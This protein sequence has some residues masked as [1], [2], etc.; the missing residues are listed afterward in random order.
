M[1]TP[2]ECIDAGVWV[3][4]QQ[5]FAVIANK[6]SAT[7]ALC[8]KQV[9]ETRLYEKLALTW[10]EFCKEYAGISRSQ[11]DRL[12]QQYEEF[13]DAYFRLSGIARVSPETYRLIA[14]QVS[15][16]GHEIDGQKLALI[17]ENGPRILARAFRRRFTGSMSPNLTPI[18]L[19][20]LGFFPREVTHVAC[21]FVITASFPN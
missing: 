11:A 9:R 5:A 19:L 20:S 15:D 18:I 14:S 12:I 3:G 21:P 2:G 16:D 13:G 17:P 10:E 7:Q 6:C 1:E 8:L 4:R